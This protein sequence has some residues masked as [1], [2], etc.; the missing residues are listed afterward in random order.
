MKNKRC[1]NCIHYKPDTEPWGERIR[2]GE[3]GRIGH[4]WESPNGDIAA[5]QDGSNYHA[6]IL[7]SKD[8][9]CVLWEAK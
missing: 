6:S 5:C 9:G 7:C 4:D 2:T 3:C 8:F 1:G